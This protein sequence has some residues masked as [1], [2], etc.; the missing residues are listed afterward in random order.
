ME[1]SK[2]NELLIL[3]DRILEDRRMLVGLTRD[4]KTSNSEFYRRKLASLEMELQHIT[5]QI[6]YMKKAFVSAEQ[7]IHNEAVVK[8]PQYNETT[9]N[10]SMFNETVINQPVLNK[11][12]Q[13]E[14]IFKD[15]TSTGEKPW[16]M[17]SDYVAPNTANSV[18]AMQ[19]PVRQYPVNGSVGP[20]KNAESDFEKTFGKS[21]M[22]IA[23]SVLVFISI[24]LFATYM[25]PMLDDSAKMVIMYLVSFGF[26]GIG[27]YRLNKDKDNKFNISLTACGLGAVFISLLL[28]NIYFGVLGDI[29]LY[30]LIAFWGALVCLFARNR[31]YIFQVI[32][33]IGILIATIFGCQLCIET[34]DV[35]KFIA[36]LVFYAITSAIF[37]FV[38]YQK[39]FR[40]NFCYHLFSV[41]GAV[42]I[43]G[44]SIDFDGTTGMVC[45]IIAI[46]ILVLNIIGCMSHKIDK[47]QEWFGIASS[48][49]MICLVVV[50]AYLISNEDIC[51]LV[52][53]A[54]GML[55]IFLASLKKSQEK[56]GVYILSITCGVIA[57]VG[58]IVNGNAYYY[59]VIWLMMIPLLIYGYVR[60]NRFCRDASLAVMLLYQFF[61]D[62]DNEGMHYVFMLIAFAIT[63]TFMYC[64]KKQYN[65]IHSGILYIAI[66]VLIGLQTYGAIEAITGY[67]AHKDEVARMLVYLC[68]FAINV[69]C[70]K[71]VFAFDLGAGEKANNENIFKVANMFAMGWG[72][73][74]VGNG[75]SDITHFVNI[76]VA[77]A[78]FMLRTKS[79]LEQ[80]EGKLSG[81]IYVGAKFTVFLIVMLCSFE[82]ANY[83]I[84]IGCLL[85]AILL[86]L[87]GFKG[88]YKYLR[89]YGLGLTM[90]SIVKLIMIDVTYENTLGNAI[91]FFVSGLLC[92]V[93]SMTYNYLDKKMKE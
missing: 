36:L 30:V 34:E 82:A 88:S 27:A 40:D 52:Y 43:T 68:F 59:G 89:I 70:Y 45:Q 64:Y 62:Y 75:G 6:D 56:N 61:Y 18:P 22:G 74:L 80:E 91:S 46:T 65:K 53:Y 4:M 41:I 21:F 81:N 86:I 93:I 29:P 63:Y 67:E 50:L 33:Q 49:Y 12:E 90:L 23:A 25:I 2:L 28:T 76:L 57:L 31:N 5:G 72:L 8:Q 11:T 7:Q 69:L 39:E 83:V 66:L 1:Q 24:I 55:M 16:Y 48:G 3:E 10:K 58:L 37:Y 85:L 42:I 47:E 60:N 17:R 26:L 44:T 77:F 79:I 51:G 71:L 78:A 9:V 87:V 13:T 38:N 20:Q 32:G 73:M 19:T 35:N 15:A 84:S 14:P 92:F 54:I